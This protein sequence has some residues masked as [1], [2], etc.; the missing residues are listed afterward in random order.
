[1]PKCSKKHGIGF[2]LRVAVQF[3]EQIVVETFDQG[4]LKWKAKTSSIVSAV[5]YKFVVLLSGFKVMVID[6]NGLF[7]AGPDFF[8][9]N[10]QKSKKRFMHEY[11]FL[12]LNVLWWK[13]IKTINYI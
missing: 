8:D 2:E 13:M 9:T 4:E 5:I 6:N 7:L 1:M 10:S 3:E 12:D 11:H